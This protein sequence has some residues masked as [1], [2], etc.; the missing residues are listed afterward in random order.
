MLEE[1]LH[2]VG[3]GLCH[4]LPERSFFAAGFQLPV[5]ARDTGIYAGFV[6]SLIVMAVLDRGRRPSELSRRWVLVVG[7]VFLSLMVAD[8]VS[9]YAGWRTTTNDLRLITGLLAGYSLP[10][11]VV[12]MVNAQMWRTVSAR[13]ALDG[14]RAGAWAA[15]APFAF[16]LLR[17]VL[18]LT[19]VLYPLILTTAI[20][21]TFTAVNLIFVTLIPV[22]EN[23]AGSLRR[24][25]LQ[26]SIALVLTV[27]ELAAASAVR[28]A[29]ES[30]ALRL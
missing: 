20:L 13:R 7:A 12:P 27:A 3:F 2:W 23:K 10:L 26:V 4:Q 16:A 9:S 18:P 11:V 5:C 30:I 14:W 22:F 19:G 15:T 28:A 21:V 29:V 8:G 24:S 1:I 17:W 25:P 6:I